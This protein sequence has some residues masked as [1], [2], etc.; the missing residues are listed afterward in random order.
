MV[1]AFYI[2]YLILIPKLFK[3]NRIFYYCLWLF[4]VIS[5][6]AITMSISWHYFPEKFLQHGVLYGIGG[7]IYIAFYYGGISTALRLGYDLAVNEEYTRSLEFQKT[8][9]QIQFMKSN[10]NI[11]F[12]VEALTYLEKV[13]SED[14]ETVKEPLLQLSN[15]LRYGTYDATED[16]I[17]F[18]K[19]LYAMEEYVGLV[20]ELEKNYSLKLLVHDLNENLAT[21]PNLL[22]KIVSFWREQL[23]SMLYGEEVIEISSVK[24]SIKMKLP[25]EP[26][27]DLQSLLLHYP[28]INSN[29]FRTR[30]F[31]F[32]QYLIIEINSTLR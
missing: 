6:Y 5:I 11:P 16:R 24:R 30:Y 32:E 27:F 13:A 18:D 9:T 8:N 22:I 10:V 29:K 7:S 2:N 3:K 19:E 28:E 31:P 14:P 25:L 4:L 1:L 12:I 20:N 21:V 23:S 15:V 17:E 26:R